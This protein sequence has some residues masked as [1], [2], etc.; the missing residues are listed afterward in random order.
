MIKSLKKI[1]MQ[2]KWVWLKKIWNEDFLCLSDMAST[3][4]KEDSIKNR[5]RNKDT[6]EFLWTWE[7]LHNPDFNENWF[8]ELWA[9]AWTNRFLMSPQKR[10]EHTN[11]I[12][13]QSTP[14]KG[15][16]TYAHVDIALEFAAHLNPAFKLYIIKDYQRLKKEE[17]YKIETNRDFKRWL[18]KINYLFMTDSIKS[19]L[20]P[21]DIRNTKISHIYAEEADLVNVALFNMTAQERKNQNKQK[22]KEWYNMRD[23]ATPEQLVVLTN[24]EFKNSELIKEWIPQEERLII[25]NDLAIQQMNRLTKK[26]KNNLLNKNW[27]ELI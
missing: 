18:T 20:I 1:N 6:I 7:M 10:K 14:W 17:Q 2:W 13:I 16:G 27:L 23:F 11:A 25:L 4:W 22:A 21:K 9:Q 3:I 5:M 26:D 12:G 24:L 8:N 19:N 15:W